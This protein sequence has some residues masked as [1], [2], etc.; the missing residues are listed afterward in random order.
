MNR[1]RARSR[2]LRAA[3]TAAE[4]ILWRE[5]RGRR[6]AMRK[7]R[8]QHPI[9]RYTV[10]FITLDGK[11][12]VE[13]DGATHSTDRERER[14]K[15]RDAELESLGFHVLRVTNTD[16]YENLDGVLEAILHELGTI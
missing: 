11:L 10:D 9:A 14:D 12:V 2:A 13:V 8:R 6:L 16:V 15:K 5:L 3:Q 4:D 7:F 1:L